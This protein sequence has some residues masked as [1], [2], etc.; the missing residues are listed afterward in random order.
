MRPCFSTLHSY[1]IR[2][3]WKIVKS[4]FLA[5]A[6]PLRIK[7]MKLVIFHQVNRLKR[8]FLPGEALPNF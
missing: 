5:S 4:Q 2:Q 1:R 3:P 6:T 7:K 8:I